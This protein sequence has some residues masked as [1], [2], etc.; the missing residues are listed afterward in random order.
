[1]K[2]KKKKKKKKK[3]KRTTVRIAMLKAYPSV[4][5]TIYIKFC[6]LFPTSKLFRDQIHAHACH[7]AFFILPEN[8]NKH[9]TCLLHARNAY[10]Y[11]VSKA[12]SSTPAQT[13]PYSDFSKTSKEHGT[14]SS[15]ALLPETPKS[16][17][18]V[19]CDLSKYR[20]LEIISSPPRHLKRKS[21]W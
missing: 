9:L 17:S 3:S 1:V 13:I 7:C 14:C 18:Y 5:Y 10:K 8:K 16:R 11:L 12:F 15:P 21:Q 20:Y 2:K 19:L 4:L 6:H